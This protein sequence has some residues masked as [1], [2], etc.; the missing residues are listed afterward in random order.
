M[1]PIYE[2]EVD[3]MVGQLC[4]KLTRAYNFKPD[5]LFVIM[6]GGLI[7]A[8][9]IETLLGLPIKYRFHY[10]KYDVNGKILHDKPELIG[11]EGYLKKEDKILIVDDVIET[12]DTLKLAYQEAKKLLKNN[13]K[14]A[15][16][17]IM[18]VS[19][20]RKG[21]N[22]LDDVVCSVISAKTIKRGDWIKFYWEEEDGHKRK[23]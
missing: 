21:N 15:E 19:L 2:Y 17:R 11:I 6:K 14:K 8:K 13:D 16:S 22:K 9:K 20:I 1:E 4:K 10:S 3:E 5:A 18:A 12:G 7:L 23:R